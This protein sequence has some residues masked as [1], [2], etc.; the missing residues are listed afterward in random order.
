MKHISLLLLLLFGIGTSL[1][2]QTIHWWKFPGNY[3]V[4]AGYDGDAP[5]EAQCYDFVWLCNDANSP[6]SIPN[7]SKNSSNQWRVFSAQ[8]D[9]A[10]DYL[11]SINVPL[12]TLKILSFEGGDFEFHDPIIFNPNRNNIV[13]KG[14]GANS[15][16]FHWVGS[17]NHFINFNHGIGS[18][19]IACG[20]SEGQ[21]TISL[22]GAMPNMLPQSGQ[23]PPY[24]YVK[25]DADP[26]VL[27]P[28]Q[29]TGT[30]ANSNGQL[31][32]VTATADNDTKLGLARAARQ[33]YLM[34]EGADIVQLQPI[35]NVGI[36]CLKI[37]AENAT[38]SPDNKA[39]IRIQHA[40]NCWVKGV[41]SYKPVSQHVI[42]DK[43][44]NIEV[45][46]CYFNQSQD[47]GPDGN[48][49]GVNLQQAAGECLI[50]NNIFRK[51]R[52]SMVVQIGAN[53]NVFAY[54][55]SRE[56]VKS[57]KADLIFH[58]RMPHHNLAEG[59][60]VEYAEFDR[61]HG[62][63]GVHNVLFRNRVNK[64]S[65]DVGG[66]NSSQWGCSV[67]ATTHNVTIVGNDV[68]DNMS[69][70]GSQSHTIHD[71]FK[72]GAWYSGAYGDNGNSTPIGT[73]LIY[74]N[75]RPDWYT[76]NWPPFGPN[77]TNSAN[78]IIPAEA[79]YNSGGL[80]TYR[81]GGCDD[82]GPFQVNRTIYPCYLNV[83]YTIPGTINLNV[84]GGFGSFTTFWQT[85]AG[86]QLL[87]SNNTQASYSG[88]GIYRSTTHDQN[89]NSVILTHYT[90]SCQPFLIDVE[91]K[92]AAESGDTAPE[93][94]IS[95]FPSP[96]ATEFKVRTTLGTPGPLE[97]K[98]FN[99]MGKMVWE[100]DVIQAPAGQQD[101]RVD[102]SR[103]ASGIYIVQVQAQQTRKFIKVIKQ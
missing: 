28:G 55:Y 60:K 79:R 64:R 25:K 46:G 52:H 75:V 20:M 101:H 72:Q 21:T 63:S 43:S 84:S 2:A 89:G 96:F 103:H 12:N 4:H 3:P 98:V 83:N 37:N 100:Q 102:L 29:A 36:E 23:V 77:S 42:I 97:I 91:R 67:N 33:N 76:G 99:Q 50:V 94:A 16:T 5:D 90:N 68:Q 34:G 53:G 73:S 14:F 32:R 41:E 71:N 44:T 85:L 51:L 95:A 22:L 31:F 65:I 47:N 69:I 8:I 45:S 35:Y 17:A 27:C 40:A 81:E 86:N 74:G 61:Y 49:Y 48:G 26:N 88:Q 56:R 70:N 13:I 93:F 80:L 58:G 57:D 30:A 10:L 24:V 9:G 92:T 7:L 66:G 62:R 82:C 11:A 54:N 19:P 18:G 6:A 87:S 78:A 1:S 38:A 15:T 59:N 39:N